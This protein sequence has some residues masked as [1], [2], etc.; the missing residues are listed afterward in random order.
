MHLV[1]KL[2]TNISES[3]DID[4]NI[5]INTNHQRT[6]YSDPSTLTDPMGWIQLG[7]SRV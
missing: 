4:L 2:H 3:F 1:V 7:F 5:R 6:A